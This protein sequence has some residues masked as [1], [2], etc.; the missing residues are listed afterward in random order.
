MSITLASG[1]LKQV[2]VLLTPVSALPQAVVTLGVAL[3]DKTPPTVWL[4]NPY[5]GPVTVPLGHLIHPAVKGL[6]NTDTEVM[7]DFRW[8]CEAPS[9]KIVGVDSFK[10]YNLSETT[11]VPPGE[12]FGAGGVN[13]VM[14]EPG[15]WHFIEKIELIP[16]SPVVPVVNGDWPIEVV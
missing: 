14:D 2:D 4:G 6:N 15:T 11:G 12:E 10:F 13:F 3:L 8:W 9:G 5:Y 1:E 16:K 7:F